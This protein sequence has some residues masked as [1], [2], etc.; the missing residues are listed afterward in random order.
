MD[1]ITDS[2]HETLIN[3]SL[4]LPRDSRKPTASVD[5]KREPLHPTVNS[6]HAFDG[7]LLVA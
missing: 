6:A 2:D 7:F 3:N 4:A 1:Q 5:L